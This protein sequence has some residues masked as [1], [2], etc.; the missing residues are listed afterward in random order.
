MTPAHVRYKIFGDRKLHV[1][2]PGSTGCDR[3]RIS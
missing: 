1:G 3:P 2:E